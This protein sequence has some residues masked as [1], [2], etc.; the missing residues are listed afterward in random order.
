MAPER[1]VPQEDSMNVAHTVMDYF[2]LNSLQGLAMIQEAG[3]IPTS[4]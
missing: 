2:E 1:A 4:H 3:L